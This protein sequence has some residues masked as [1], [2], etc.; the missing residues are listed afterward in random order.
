MFFVT[1]HLFWHDDHLFSKKN[2]HF[3]LKISTLKQILCVCGAR[4]HE[5]VLRI[6]ALERLS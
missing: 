2:Q 6:N 1:V 3:I 4:T 5:S